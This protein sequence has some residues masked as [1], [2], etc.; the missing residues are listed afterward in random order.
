M[1]VLNED[2][3]RN[4]TRQGLLSPFGSSACC[5]RNALISRYGNRPDDRHA[6]RRAVQTETV[7]SWP[8]MANG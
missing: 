8:G 7:F 1:E 3:V 4:R 2:Y 5:L 6:D